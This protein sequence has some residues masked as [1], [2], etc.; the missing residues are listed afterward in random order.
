MSEQFLQDPSVDSQAPWFGMD[1]LNS[2]VMFISK[3]LDVLV[4]ND[5]AGQLLDTHVE[6]GQPVAMEHCLRTDREEYQALVNMVHSERE[7]RDFVMTWEVNGRIRHVLIDSFAKRDERRQ[8]TGIYVFMKDLG[9]FTALEQQMQRSDKLATVGKIAA[10]I[11]HEI[12]N[13]LTTLKGFLQMMDG[14]FR[15]REMAVELQYTDVMLKEIE[16]VNSLV[17][18]LLLLSKPHKVEKS[19]CSIPALLSELNPLLQ[20]QALLHGIDYVQ[21]IQDVPP[22]VVDTALLKQVVLNLVKNALEAMDN[23]G[24]ALGITV[25]V[26]EDWLYI[27]VSD[28]GPGIPYYQMDKIFDAFFT[29]K[30]KGTGLGLP[31]CQRIIADHGG[32]IRVSSKGFGA[33]FS[34]L[35][36]IFSRLQS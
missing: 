12:R 19:L 2:G 13:P 4:Y 7:Y 16:R 3:S 20:S 9:N 27:D 29:T 32:E 15:E 22:V 34:I 26:A 21:D 17:G 31:I 5:L 24:G 8:C 36:P 6:I 23:G 33:T 1:C 30:E 25:H 10:G 18:E 14:R 28:T 35:L 11:A